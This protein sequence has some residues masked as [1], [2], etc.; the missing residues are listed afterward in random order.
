[1]TSE[2]KELWWQYDVT[3]RG[4][5]YSNHRLRWFVWKYFGRY[6]FKM[7]IGP[8]N[9]PRVCLLRLFGAK[10]GRGNYIS[11]HAIIVYPAA[12]S[13]GR[14]NAID[15]YVYFNADTIIGNRCQLSSFVKIISGGHDVRSRHFEYQ[16]RPVCIGDSVFVGANST[17]IGGVRIGDFAAVGA[18]SFVLNDICENTISYGSPCKEHSTRIPWEQYSNYS[19]D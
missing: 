7:L 2:K 15:D 8:L 12:L 13:L 16:L 17:I 10:I 4:K 11:N 9:G 6:V 14:E 18:N 1:M 5:E 3:S 19:F